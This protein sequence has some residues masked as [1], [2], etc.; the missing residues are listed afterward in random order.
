MRARSILLT[1]CFLAGLR[2]AGHATIVGFGQLGGNNVT[3]PG[4]LASNATADANGCV[5]SNGTTPNISLAWDGAW[6]IHT[7]GFFANL[8]NLTVGSGAWDNEGGVPRVGQLDTGAHTIIFSSDPGYAL[9]L[10]S[11][12]F[13]HT[14][15]TSGSTVWDLTLTDSSSNLVWSQT[16]TLNNAGT[17]TS[18]V[19]VTPGLTGDVGKSYT[20]AFNRT[21]QTY[22]SDGRHAVDNLS[23]NQVPTGGEPPEDPPVDPGTALS[24]LVN[25]MVGV[26]GGSGTGSCVPG[27]CLPLSSIYPSP[28]TQAAAAGGFAPGSPVVGFSQLHATGSGSSTMSFGNFLVSPRLGAGVTEASHASPIANVTARPYSYRGRLTTWNTDCT[29]VPT[30]NSAIYQ[31][32]FPVSSDARIN[33][34]I[35]RKLNSATGMTNGSISIDPATGT[36]SGGGT[37]DGNWNPAAYN[38]YFYAK[39]DAAPV[40]G[41]TFVGSTSQDGVLTASTATRQRLG[42]WLRFDT[43][44]TRTVRMKIAVSFSSVDRARQY[45]ENE[46]PA[47]DLAGH[48]AAA[49]TK[50]NDAL[51]AVRTPGIKL[52]AAT[53]LYTALFH[54]LIQPRN[55][56]G[57]PAGWPANAA[58]WDDQYTLWDTW[59]THFP[60]LT[61]VSPDSAA[62]IVNSFA[63]RFERNGR[64]E[65]A[66]IQGKDFQVGQGGDEVDRAICDAYVKGIPGIDW[67]RVWPLLKFN[68]AR[69]TDD[70]RNLGFVSTDGS[71]GGYD[72]RMGSGSS[73]LAFAHGDWCAAQVAQGL[74]HTAEAAALL[75]R[76]QNWRNVWDASATGD[77]FSGFVRGRARNGVFAATSPTSTSNF[78][79]GTPWNYSFSIP[80]DQDGAIGLMGGRARFLQR[81]EFAF[82]TNSTAYVDF[83]NEVNLKATALF[84]HAGRP[85]LQSYWADILRQRFGT[86][87]YPG[88]ED[89]GAMSSTYF[90]VTAGLFPS[91]TQD[92][93]YLSGPRVPRLEFNVGNGKTF[94]IAAAESGGANTFIQ[95]ATLDGQPLDT[96]VIRH[97]DIMAGKTLA[98]VMGPNPSV[99]GTGG[100]FAPSAD[101]DRTLP[102]SGDWTAALGSPVITG[103]STNAP[104]WGGGPNGADN[105]AIHSEFPETNLSQAGDSITLTS[106]VALNGMTSSQSS[107]SARFAWGLFQ[108]NGT[109]NT[110]W[111]GYL[112]ANDTSDTAGTLN[113][114][115]RFAGSAEAWHTT[116]GASPAASFKLATPSFADGSYRLMLTVTRTSSDALDYHAA[117]VRV[118]DG[119]LFAAF[120]GSDLT[121]SAFSFNRAVLRAGE[122]LD[123]DS[124]AVS[125]FS[126]V[127][128]GPSFVSPPSVAMTSPSQGAGYDAQA[129]VPLTATASDSDGA[130]TRVEFF[131]GLTKLGEDSTAPYEF[132][133]S[134]MLSG[135]YQLTAR[136]TD[137][138]GATATSAPVGVTITN[139]DNSPPTVELTAPAGGQTYVTDPITITADA[140]DADGVV[141]KVE[142]FDGATKLGED[143]TEPFE[144]AWNGASNGGHTLTAVATDNDSAAT[145]SS[146]VN[147][148]VA[149]P[150]TT[151]LIARRPAGQPGAVWKYLDNGSDQGTAWKETAYDDSAWTSG[152]APL[153]YTDSHIVTTVNSPASPN[154][155]ITTYF[156]RTFEITGAAAIQ[157]LELNILRDDGVVVYINGTEVARQNMPAGSI[158][159]T[160]N[161]STIV[162]GANETTYF[163]ST[164]APHPLLVEGTNVIAVEVHQRDAQSSDLG[165]DLEMTAVSLP[166]PTVTMTATDA[167]AGEF[168]SDQALEF[169][170]TRTGSTALGLTVPLVASGSAGAA[171]YTGFTNSITIPATRASVSLP[172]VVAT[173]DLSE[174]TETVT[175]ALGASAAFTA[176]SPASADAVIADKPAQDFY[177]LNIPDPAL[178]ATGADA[179]GDSQANIVE[180]FMGTLPADAGSKGILEIPSIGTNTFKV[181]YPRAKN[182]T[183][184]S[185]SLRWSADLKQWR[186]SGQSDGSH[187][188]TFTEAVVSV[189]GAN[190]ETVEATATITGPGESPKIF[191]RLGVE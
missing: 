21:S 10:N 106:V 111:P 188:V 175:V 108:S 47:W 2:T 185:G 163:A 4:N 122:A 99:W 14:A 158:T 119:V 89:S 12:D 110:G 143:A 53:R 56:T 24:D 23:F 182:R 180:Y 50:W 83:S 114:W 60:L 1:L 138:D 173:D 93:Y 94:T 187:T 97:S 160:T 92:V 172:L 132:D 61:L 18:V 164:A 191:V 139:L 38:V 25:P 57:D 189:P 169:T 151:T 103:T 102:M 41:G 113:F 131:A 46:I 146:A 117:L 34:D 118:S 3:V 98:F 120:S 79:Q 107:P 121:P 116:T 87:T 15:E 7:S 63:E 85:Y 67:E 40:S 32:D 44:T 27:A 147:L 141:S 150:L 105:S 167:S 162:D 140:A 137:D 39:V 6:D 28:D 77:G 179:D 76:S 174:G 129:T 176:G 55:R 69:R 19:K 48:E 184:V 88:D 62:A 95:S 22:S 148:T 178:R 82:S 52:S 152:A 100:D 17:A 8:E 165:F 86:L 133:W 37:F 115:K 109:G 130:I 26:S 127:A 135:S 171:D 65:T 30:A 11:F 153:G 183:D 190:P 166:L 59:H 20:L 43:I 72:S 155:Y 154:R 90:F 134:G 159:S 156:R 81:L 186:A 104:V 42:G 49:K 80:H 68:A 51:S 91:A 64:A 142:F 101:P 170:I 75:S 66:F 9:V 145:A 161:S 70:Y 181:R 45:L 74:G 16:L 136:A 13:C 112:A 35:A 144:F 36:I 124:I 71:R 168:G 125:G 177:F 84:G 157:A 58:Y 123:A 149:L 73:T 31:F 126:V 96:P 128:N 29:V 5:V 54:S 33:F 78:Y